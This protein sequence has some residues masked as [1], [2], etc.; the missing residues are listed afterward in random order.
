MNQGVIYLLS[1][2]LLTGMGG[3]FVKLTSGINSQQILF[4]RAILAVVFLLGVAIAT[5]NVH[6]LKLKHVLGTI[7]MGAVQ[8]LSIYFYYVALGKTT[9]TNT[10]LLVYTA[11]IFSVIL[12]AI[13][14]KERIEKRTI[15]GIIISFFGVLIVS[16]PTKFSVSQN[17]MWGSI[18]A[19]LGGFFYSAMAISSKSVTSKTTPLYAAFWQYLVIGILFMPAAL[20]L[21]LDAFTSNLPSLLYLGWVAGGL[22]F[23]LYMSGINKVK[24]QI[25]QVVTMLE[26]VVASLSGIILLGE[27]I[28]WPTIVGGLCIVAGIIIVSAK[29]KT[30]A[31]E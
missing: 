2:S 31:K 13:F 5:K 8:G 23:L 14:L 25:I 6:Q 15:I 30:I 1:F 16:D 26:I 21:S 17:H 29:T 22:A 27:K 10:T 28:E 20:P 12:S 7:L 18:F 4:I 19:L 9:I 3:Y 24:G 11:P